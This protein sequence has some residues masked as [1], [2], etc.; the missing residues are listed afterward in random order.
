MVRILLDSSEGETVL[1]LRD[2]GI[3]FDAA[4]DGAE[5]HAKGDCCACGKPPR[6]HR[7]RWESNR[8]H[9]AAR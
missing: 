6:R 9:F 4:A 8:V 2:D 7:A 5:R 3:G 1:T